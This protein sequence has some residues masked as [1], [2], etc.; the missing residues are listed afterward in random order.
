MAR[1]PERH[2]APITAILCGIACKLLLLVPGLPAWL[3]VALAST[4]GLF[5]VSGCTG[6]VLVFVFD[7]LPGLG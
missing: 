2:V 1:L 7:D 6:F 4:F 3:S 5:T